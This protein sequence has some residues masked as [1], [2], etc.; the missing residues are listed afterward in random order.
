MSWESWD[1]GSIPS[2]A[3]W[4][5]DPEL[6]QLQLRWQPPLGSD[7]WPENSICCG[8]ARKKGREG[9]RSTYSVPA[10]AQQVKDPMLSLW[11]H[12]GLRIQHCHS[13][14]IS[15]S[16]GSDSIIGPE[17]SICHRCGEKRKKRRKR[18]STYNC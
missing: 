2:P 18:S 12:S 1:T 8:A 14:G 7:P 3:P 5:K 16:Y 9:G 4:L 17:I 6:L 10:V 15:Q 11:Q 13:C